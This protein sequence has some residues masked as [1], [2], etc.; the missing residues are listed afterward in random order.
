M[1][2]LKL[3]M[4][5][6]ASLDKV[7]GEVINFEEGALGEST[8]FS[9]VGVTGSG[10]STILDAICLALYNRAPRYPRKK[11]DR[12]QNIEIYGE[13]EEG[14]KNRLPPTD[15]RNILTRG[16]KEGYSKLTFRANDGTIYRA[17]WY[18]KKL[19]K[20][21]SE[22]IKNLY[23]LKFEDGTWKPEVAQ[24]DL[25]PQIIGLDFD[26]FLR[27]VV[28]AQGSFSSFIKAKE[29]ERYELLEK[30]VGCKE[31]YTDMA[32]K[33]RQKKD[34]ATMHYKEI[35]ADFAAQEKDLLSE[36]EVEPLK[37]RISELEEKEK[38]LKKE[39][40]NIT[41]Q[42][43]W[44]ITNEK[45]LANIAR[46][47]SVFEGVKRQRDI[48]R[49]EYERLRLH[50]IAEVAVDI[51]KAIK[52]SES[53]IFK[54]QEE[55]NDLNKAINLK[56]KEITEEERVVLTQLR[57]EAEQAVGEWEK[58]KPH[59]KRAFEIKTAIDGLKKTQKEREK[60]LEIAQNAYK[61]AE[62]L[63]EANKNSIITA[64]NSL[65]KSQKDNEVLK[66]KI[67]QEERE[68]DKKIKTAQE[69]FETQSSKLKEFDLEKLQ[70]EKSEADKRL[71]DINKAIRIQTDLKKKLLLKENYE[72]LKSKLEQQNEKID[73]ELKKFQIEKLTE[74]LDTLTR[75][76]TLMTSDNWSVHRKELKAGEACPLCGATD[77]PYEDENKVRPMI[78][79]MKLMIEDWKKNLLDQ[80]KEKETLENERSKNT[81]EL[82]GIRRYI[83]N[84][85]S[86]IDKL[87]KEW[88]GLEEI[89]PLE[90]VI[91]NDEK[92][93]KFQELKKKAEEK[94]IIVSR[95]LKEYNQLLKETEQLREEKDNTE[96]TRQDFIKKSHDLMADAEAK[97]NTAYTLLSTEKGKTDNLI[98]QL[99]EKSNELANAHESKNLIE[100]EILSVTEDFKKETGG[101]DPELWEKELNTAK[102]KAEK[103]VVEKTIFI[104]KLREQLSE[105]QG[106]E[107]EIRKQSEKETL[108]LKTKTEALNQWLENHN[109][110]NK[111]QPLTQGEIISLYSATDNWEEMRSR[112]KLI[113]ERYTSAETTLKN[114]QEAFFAHQDNKPEEEKAFLEN[115]KRELEGVS[116]DELV[117]SKAR[118][119]RHEK[120]REEM[121][122]IFEKKLAAEKEKQNWEEIT[123]AI[124][125]DGKILRKIAQCY[126]LRFLIEHA[127]VEIRK[128]NSRYE[129]KQVNNSLGIRVID[130]DR[131]DDVRDTTSLSGG[132]TFIVSLGMAL[133]LSSLSSRN[134]SL[135]NIFIDEGF[136]SLDPETLDTMIDSL[137]ILQTS[138]NKKVGV[139]SHTETISERITTQIRVLKNGNTG[140]SRIEVYPS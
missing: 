25:L 56:N 131:A 108:N 99:K 6:L 97:V 119:Q 122:V 71:A 114:E 48:M 78:D 98:Q 137:S 24:W 120:A 140:S 113:D 17:E 67:L 37:Q 116:Q 89:G 80:K 5:N 64:E 92:E 47:T 123:D 9:I 32:A 40:S 69:R 26:Q 74:D 112:Q 115:K 84:L 103:R 87:K 44:Y 72:G 31:V 96:K 34:E 136:G 138:Q 16:K 129:L 45:Y 109:K 33:I 82:T 59:I 121:G 81:G 139:I 111:E 18:V 94:V 104:S 100:G 62:N 124:G 85:L 23:K 46:Y 126:T 12:N 30:L 20:N 130:H 1:K 106:R 79:K 19:Q 75:S 65:K 60:A 77:H 27:T 83:E 107:N 127:N 101:K 117:N 55:Q 4:L 90:D 43:G 132:E 10:K 38:K 21:F 36:E 51:Y 42:I 11:G 13:L 2:F 93:A 91:K 118:L 14:E 7:G 110:K 95:N 76:Y 41:E 88:E 135:G 54:F 125:I 58:Q 49:E 61:K 57:K 50:D 68:L 128:F 22:P 86:E 29:D 15:P 53:K 39:L 105:M 133:G 134:I 66:V 35:V 8:I 73:Q 3:E 70:E 102:E 63:L 52:I 28:I